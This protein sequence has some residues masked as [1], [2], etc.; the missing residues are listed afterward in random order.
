MVAEK[1]RG[2]DGPSPQPKR[3]RKAS[4]AVVSPI[5][6]SPDNLQTNFSEEIRND[7]VPSSPSTLRESLVIGYDDDTAK[8][9]RFY[10]QMALHRNHAQQALK[11]VNGDLPPFEADPLNSVF[12]AWFIRLR[13]QGIRDD[14]LDLQRV[15]PDGLF[16]LDNEDRRKSAKPKPITKSQQKRWIRFLE[17]VEEI[18]HPT[19]PA[20]QDTVIEVSGTGFEA[21]IQEPVRR[22]QRVIPQSDTSTSASINTP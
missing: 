1:I 11:M 7:N 21:Q 13:M 15:R 3:T 20:G 19:P 8:Q 12:I 22:S 9:V 5:N 16:S 2:E 18:E 17:V 4:I 6:S 14:L 10:K